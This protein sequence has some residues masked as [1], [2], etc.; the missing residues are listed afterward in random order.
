M[1]PNHI[2]ELKRVLKRVAT[3]T[4]VSERATGV[5]ERTTGVS[6]RTTTRIMNERERRYS[7]DNP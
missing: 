6:E 2:R 1:A 5:S 3:A 7:R 4:G